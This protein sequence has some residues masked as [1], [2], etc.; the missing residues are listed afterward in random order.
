[1]PDKNLCGAFFALAERL[2]TSATLFGALLVASCKGYLDG[3]HPGKENEDDVVGS[4]I[5]NADSIL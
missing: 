1:M 3:N 5:A 2:P 4:Y